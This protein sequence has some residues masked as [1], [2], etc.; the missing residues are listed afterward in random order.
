MIQFRVDNLVSKIK[1][2]KERKSLGK[3]V[4]RLPVFIPSL[5]KK[6]GSEAFRRHHVLKNRYSPWKMRGKTGKF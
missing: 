5:H 4:L 1:N 3:Y 2:T 6:V